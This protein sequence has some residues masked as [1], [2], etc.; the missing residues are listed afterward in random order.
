MLGPT[1]LAD[2]ADQVLQAL[3]FSILCSPLADWTR[4]GPSGD[5]IEFVDIRRIDLLVMRYHPFFATKGI[6]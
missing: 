5:P 4:V 6:H 3:L 2:K 1:V